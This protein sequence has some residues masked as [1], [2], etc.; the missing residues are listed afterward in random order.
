MK[1][2]IENK[3]NDKDDE[4]EVILSFEKNNILGEQVGLNVNGSYGMYFRHDKTIQIYK[5]SL[6]EKGFKIE[7]K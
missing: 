1:F 3:K 4:E 7:I 2:K 6:E 5:K